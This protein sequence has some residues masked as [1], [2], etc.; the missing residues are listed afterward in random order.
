MPGK[1]PLPKDAATRVRRNKTGASLRVIEVQPTKQPEL[2]TRYKSVDSEEGRF[3]DI[4]D[5]PTATVEWWSMWA[6]SPL[7]TEFTD[8][9]WEELKMAALL[10]AQF[11]EGDYKLAG[12][13]RLRTAK[14]GTTPED[15][16]RLKIQFA[17]ADEAEERT[18]RRKSSKQPKPGNDPRL[19]LA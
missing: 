18:E 6:A 8:S 7:S 19:K 12:E 3:T 15:R 5:W 11:V 1:G 16:A 10:H 17:L 2:P 13:L 9:D 14:F 4:V